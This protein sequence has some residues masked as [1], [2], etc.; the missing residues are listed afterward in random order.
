MPL[1]LTQLP[2]IFSDNL[3]IPLDV[4]S[5]GIALV[6]IVA[7]IIFLAILDVNF[8]VIF[9]VSMIE[10]TLFTFMQWFPIYI[11]IIIALICAILVGYV[12]KQYTSVSS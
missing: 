2:E 4:S 8:V 3:G 11:T 5:I 6:I 9:A 12:V 7:T 10:L 1:N